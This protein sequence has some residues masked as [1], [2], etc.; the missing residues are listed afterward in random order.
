MVALGVGASIA[1]G[2][3][4]ILLGRGY[5]EL[6]RQSDSAHHVNRG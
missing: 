3:V 5:E 6:R 4:A 1:W 2:A